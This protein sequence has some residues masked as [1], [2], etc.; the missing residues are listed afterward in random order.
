M[1]F[2]KIAPPYPSICMC[3]KCGYRISKLEGLLCI[4]MRCPKCNIA[5]IRKDLPI[6]R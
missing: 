6:M 5:L 2:R 3:P 1:S 4:L